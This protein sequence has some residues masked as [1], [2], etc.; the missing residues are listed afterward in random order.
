ML[1]QLCILSRNWEPLIEESRFLKQ[2][3]PL[4]LIDTGQHALDELFQMLNTPVFLQNVALRFAVCIDFRSAEGSGESRVLQQTEAF[5][6]NLLFHPSYYTEQAVPRLFYI[7]TGVHQ[8]D[9]HCCCL[10]TEHIYEQGYSHVKWIS[11]GE[12]RSEPTEETVPLYRYAEPQLLYQTYYNDFLAKG[13]INKH[14]VVDGTQ[15]RGPLWEAQVQQAETDL[16]EVQ[17]L[18]FKQMQ[19]LAETLKENA[20]LKWKENA[21]RTEVENYKTY[22]Q[23]IHSQD[24]AGKINAFYH[25]EYEVLPLWFKRLGHVIKVVMGKRTFTSLYDKGKKKYRS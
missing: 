25:N 21:G 6:H 1:N 11:I 23:L 22:L 2:A 19:L 24:E 5:I 7:S 3:I 9:T 15:V 18:L 13:H 20:V 10:F 17:P 16:A 14:V 8:Q 12:D 4:F